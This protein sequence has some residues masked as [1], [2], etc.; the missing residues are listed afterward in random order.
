MSLK[1]RCLGMAETPVLAAGT[2]TSRVFFYTPI[3]LCIFFSF[4]LFFLQNNI[5]RIRGESGRWPLKA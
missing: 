5:R 4:F 2:R 3:F 1:V